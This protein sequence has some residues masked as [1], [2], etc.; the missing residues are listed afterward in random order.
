MHSRHPE[1]SR[2]STC[3]YNVF[4]SLSFPPFPELHEHQGS[5]AIF[6]WCSDFRKRP[7]CVLRW[8]NLVHAGWL[9]PRSEFPTLGR[10]WGG[11]RNFFHS[12]SHWC[13]VHCAMD[14]CPVKDSMSSNGLCVLRR[15]LIFTCAKLLLMC[16]VSAYLK[17]SRRVAVFFSLERSWGNVCK[18]WRAL[19]RRRF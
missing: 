6:R 14:S 10:E 11:T 17:T 18:D 8:L 13:W 12:S 15:R 1:Q 3:T 5:G 4:H 2:S 7:T 9:K 16:F 19:G